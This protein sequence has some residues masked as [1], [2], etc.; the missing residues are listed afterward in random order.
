MVCVSKSARPLQHQY[1][2][3]EAPDALTQPYYSMQARYPIRSGIHMSCHYLFLSS[4]NHVCVCVRA[5]VCGQE[6]NARCP[7]DV[8]TVR[9]HHDSG[10]YRYHAFTKR[11]CYRRGRV[12]DSTACTV[13]VL[14]NPLNSFLEVSTLNDYSESWAQQ[15]TC[16]LLTREDTCSCG[17]CVVTRS[18]A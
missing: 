10:R 12:R 16:L 13:S 14:G 9:T 3:T 4:L 2:S 17:Y 7:H 11:E 15:C 1:A 6:S 5:R 18:T 8:K